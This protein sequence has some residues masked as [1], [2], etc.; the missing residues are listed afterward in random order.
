MCRGGRRYGRSHAK[1]ESCH[2]LTSWGA[3]TWAQTG[4]EDDDN[5]GLGL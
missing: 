3:W 4:E 2:S 5:G 1:V